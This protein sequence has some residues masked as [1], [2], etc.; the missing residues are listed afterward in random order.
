MLVTNKNYGDNEDVE[1]EILEPIESIEDEKDYL[2][3]KKGM[4]R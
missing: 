2:K 1:E 3:T 4:K